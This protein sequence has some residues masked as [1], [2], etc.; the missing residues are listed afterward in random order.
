MTNSIVIIPAREGSKGIRNKNSTHIL[1]RSLVVRSIFHARELVED[2]Q[3]VISTDS[4]TIL[5]EIAHYFD[6]EIRNKFENNSISTLGPFKVHFRDQK[7]SQDSTLITEVLFACRTLLIELDEVPI[8]WCLL[9]PTSPFRSAIELNEIKQ[10][11]EKNSDPELSLV[12]ITNVDGFHPARMYQMNLDMQLIELP[13]F[14]ESRNFRRQD[15][16]KVFIRDGGYY[17]IGDNLV[18]NKIQYSIKPSGILRF[19]P[20]SINIDAYQDLTFANT[21]QLADVLQ[22]PNSTNNHD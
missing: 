17:L 13:I 15:L 20:W 2:S 18:K 3:I 12:S 9:Q 10:I 19:I 22:D 1:N 5:K 21:F 7:L 16:P 4:I 11:L 14:K 8:T 6:F